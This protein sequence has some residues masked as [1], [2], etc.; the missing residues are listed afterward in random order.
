VKFSQQVKLQ[1]SVIFFQ[2]TFTKLFD[3]WSRI[4][5][6]HA[7]QSVHGT[8]IA[9]NQFRT[10]QHTQEGWLALRFFNTT[11]STIGIYCAFKILCLVTR[12][13]TARKSKKITLSGMK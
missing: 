3:L 2:Q 5:V 11:V 13:I 4:T 8:L 1:L 6:P 9:V 10:R 12:K 7:M